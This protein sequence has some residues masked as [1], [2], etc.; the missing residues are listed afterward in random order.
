M[1]RFTT[2]ARAMA[3]CAVAT[4]VSAHVAYPQD[5]AN[6]SFEFGADPNADPFEQSLLLVAPDRTSVVGWTVSRG[7]VDYIGSRWV[8]GDGTRCLDLAGIAPGTIEQ[9]IKGFTP[10]VRYRLTLLVAPSPEGGNPTQRV[11]LSIGGLSQVFSATDSGTRENLG[12]TERAFDFTAIATD[13]TVSF[14][15]LEPSV[16][17]PALDA[18]R[19]VPVLD[20]DGDGVLDH[21][22][23][24]VSS[25]LRSTVVIDRCDSTVANSLFP[26]GCSVADLVANC[27]DHGRKHHRFVHCIARLTDAMDRIGILTSP[28]KEAIQSCAGQADV[29]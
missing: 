23:Q 15:S 29:P 9:N 6:G 27:T 25:D 20:F 14:T 4:V 16:F 19:I 13:M 28:Q 1:R 24:C 11:Q 12:W 10:G 22:D 21:D 18:V 2:T 3:I 7:S 17:G 5:L 8:C 26:S